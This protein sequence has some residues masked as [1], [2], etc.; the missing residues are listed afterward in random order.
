MPKTIDK[1]TIE[2]NDILQKLLNILEIS[3][4]NK[5][6]SLKNL[7]ENDTK[8][9]LIIELESDIK[10]Y[11]LCSRWTYFSN[12]N[13]EFKC[14]YLS[15][16]KAIMKDLNIQMTS[17]TLIKKTNDNKTKCETFYIFDI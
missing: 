10:K 12:K 15:L 11:F 13:R 9:K 1:Y 7:D 17:S 16:I 14:S 3:D 4:T 2:R 6:F 8:Q 5:T